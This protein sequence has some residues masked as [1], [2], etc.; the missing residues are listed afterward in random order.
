MKTNKLIEQ[1]DELAQRCNELRNEQNKL[2]DSL[3]AKI[4]SLMKRY[5][6]PC[7]G[8][9]NFDGLFGYDCH[10]GSFAIFCG[11]CGMSTPHTTKLEE[12]LKCFEAIKEGYVCNLDNIRTRDGDPIP[13]KKKS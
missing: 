5:K 3:Y 8:A 13:N 4:N 1:I 2:E 9:R 7:C 6:C 12:A 10:G 11:T